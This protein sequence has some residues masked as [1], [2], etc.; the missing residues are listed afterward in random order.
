VATSQRQ[1]MMILNVMFA[2]LVDTG[3]FAGNLVALSC[4][5]RSSSAGPHMA[6]GNLDLRLVPIASATL[7]SRP[8]ACIC[9]ATTISVTAKRNKS[10]A[11]TGE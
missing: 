6:D 1:A 3:F 8:R 5:P 7:R 9:T 11:S 10:T 2:W 4:V